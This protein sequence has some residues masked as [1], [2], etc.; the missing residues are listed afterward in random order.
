VPEET[1]GKLLAELHTHAAWA[2]HPLGIGGESQAAQAP[3][4]LP[5]QVSPL[6]IPKPWG[7]IMRQPDSARPDSGFLASQP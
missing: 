1:P 5:L 6:R 4:R 7:S 3:N 2:M